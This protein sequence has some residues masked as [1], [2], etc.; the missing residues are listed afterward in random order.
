[1]HCDA[2]AA[3]VGSERTDAPVRLPEGDASVVSEIDKGSV[4]V[5]IA[6]RICSEAS[7]GEVIVSSSIRK[8]AVGS[9]IGLG[10]RGLYELRGVPG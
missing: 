6:A 9:A 8:I 7:T 2:T 1:M 3:L 5:H 10:D 4:A